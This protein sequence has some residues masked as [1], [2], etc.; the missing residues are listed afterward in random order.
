MTGKGT[1]K[2]ILGVAPKLQNKNGVTYG[3]TKGV[4]QKPSKIKGLR[5]AVT[6]FTPFFKNTYMFL[7]NFAIL[8]DFRASHAKFLKK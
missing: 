4:T 6:P 7:R 1:S 5:G 8:H 2:C 3:V